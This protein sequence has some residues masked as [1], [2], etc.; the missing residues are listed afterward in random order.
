MIRESPKIACVLLVTLLFMSFLPGCNRKPTKGE[1]GED[2]TFGD[3]LIVFVSDRLP[4]HDSS[5]FVMKSDGTILNRFWGYD[6]EVWRTPL[7][8]PGGDRIAVTVGH[9]ESSWPMIVNTDGSGAYELAE[10]IWFGGVYVG[11][12]MPDGEKLVYHAAAYNADTAEIG[13][14]MINPDGSGK[15]KLDQGY[16]PR[17]CGHDKVVYTRHDGIFIISI[18]G[19][20]RRRLQETLPGVYVYKPV[21]SPDG[22]KVVFCRAVTLPSS[23]P[24]K[25]EYWLEIINSDS[26]GH[27]RLAQF[28]EIPTFT[29]IEFSPEGERVSLLIG[30]SWSVGE[31][32][33]INID[34]SGLR[35]L[36]NNTAHP[37][38]HARWSPDGSRIVYT[39]VKDGNREIYTVTAQGT[40][41]M[42]NLTNNPSFDL[43]PD[44]CRC[45]VDSRRAEVGRRGD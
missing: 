17:V 41:V 19:E 40:P 4:P 13:V 5:L 37:Y 22:K 11:G 39:S 12:W 29:D 27:A 45:N 24:V 18:D 25:K 20:G 28:A 2:Q 36:T 16:D 14:F 38:G 33:V 9:E 42:R 30:S 23:N 6:F 43:K 15:L 26:S 31:I 32:Y 34:G 35:P 7:L 1:N 44:W 8:S 3:D 10:G 21:G